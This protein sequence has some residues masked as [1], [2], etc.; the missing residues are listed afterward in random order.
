MQ[1]EPLIG[2]TANLVFDDAGEH[3][4]VGDNVRFVIARADQLQRGIEAEN[5]LA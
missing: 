4:G 2:I 1:P 3:S 5:V